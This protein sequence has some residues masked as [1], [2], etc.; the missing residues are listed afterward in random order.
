MKEI[1]AQR[2]LYPRWTTKGVA[3]ALAGLI[4]LLVL[5]GLGAAEVLTWSLRMVPELGLIIGSASLLYLLPGLALLRL[6]WRDVALAWPEELALAL[7]I[8]V[9]LPPLLLEIAHLAGL[10]WQGWTTIAYL[11]LA[12]MLL[13]GHWTRR[14]QR[15]QARS[16]PAWHGLLLLGMVG[17]AVLVRLYVVRDL[18]VG[19]WGDSYHHTMIAQLLVN[20]HGLFSSWE[21][22]A[23]LATFTYHYGFHANVAFFHWLTGIP[24]TQSV[25]DVGQILNAATI[26]LAYALAVRVTRSSAAGLWSAVLTGFVN[27]QPAYYTNWGRYTQL[28]G[29]L[30]L[31][32]VLVCWMDALERDRLNWRLVALAAIMTACL[33][34][35]HYIVTIFAALFLLGYLLAMGALKPSWQRVQQICIGAAAISTVALL[36]AS[37]WLLRVLGGHLDRNVAGFVN[38][39]VGAERIASYSSLPPVTPF[40]LK[41]PILALAAIGLLIAL[42]RRD[43]RVALLAV[44]SQLLVLTIVPQ[45]VGLPGAGVVDNLTAYIALY[46]PVI[47]LAAYT[48][49]A[50]QELLASR[51]A[52]LA[53]FVASG[54]LVAT[55][56]WGSNWQQGLIDPHYQLFTAA[57]AEAMAWIRTHTPATARFLVN[58]F[59]A[60]GGTVIAGTDGGWWLPLLTGRQS[61]L[62][63]ITYGSERAA[64]EDYAPRVNALAAA[65]RD[66]PLTNLTPIQVDLT[67]PAA[68]EA[69]RNAGI[70]Y[71]YSGA[72]AAP[73]P[74]EADHIDTEK[75]RAAPDR[76][77]P[78]YNRDGA[79]IFAFETAP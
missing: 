35:T 78:V 37:P 48:L 36:L 72:H 46:L 77:R 5:V 28:A 41:G 71:I 75:L 47:P 33:M 51:R 8:G 42:A 20:N 30:V 9:A 79:M 25:L 19:M 66:S 14:K 4:S 50:A 44:W 68:V 45:T 70:D 57:D 7:G 67:T 17:L 3:Q 11:V 24:V 32:V 43:W 29:Q 31:P 39:E 52:Q 10:P 38:G 18:P 22:Y 26:P 59:P 60:F 6:L 74:E 34:L 65:L 40:H 76:F 27:T 49:G 1:A 58:S 16:L 15:P 62:P 55:T 2:A 53:G 56:A 21:P 69:L 63:P 23:P 13:A 73:G 64:Q 12:A 54:A 61:N